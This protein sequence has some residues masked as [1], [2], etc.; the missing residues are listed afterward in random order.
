MT[1]SQNV[2]KN[3][4]LQSALEVF[5]QKGFH[6]TKMDDIAQASGV[7]KGALYLYFR[8]KK[9]LYE[10]I[11]QYVYSVL[12]E[13]IEYAIDQAGE[14]HT[15]RLAAAL[16]AGLELFEKHKTLSRFVLSVTQV[17]T[18]F[19]DFL[20]ELYE[21]L[22]QRI[23]D[24]LKESDVPYDDEDKEV[25]AWMWVGALHIL[26]YRWLKTGKPDHLTSLHPLIFQTLVSGL[27]KELPSRKEIRHETL[28]EQRA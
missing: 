11:L 13:K 4:I 5:A 6:E 28:E 14:S 3:V 7:S 1:H 18:P 25:L 24:E 2:T 22:V 12:L 15:A 8:S 21:A 10:A 26:V 19:S 23:M 16:H 20:F 9:A 17:G 27:E